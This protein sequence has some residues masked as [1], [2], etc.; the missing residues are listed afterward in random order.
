ML[1]LFGAAIAGVP[2]CPL[3]YRLADE[4]LG[5]LLSRIAPALVVG[6]ASR[7]AQLGG[8]AQHAILPRAAFT[9]A[10]L[11]ADPTEEPTGDGESIAIQ[12]FTSGTTSAPKAAI[13]TH[14]NLVSYIVGTV[15]FGAAAEHE[16]TLVSV[17]PYHS[18]GIAALLSSVYA[19]RRIVL[20]PAFAPEAWLQLVA[21]ERVTNAFVVPTMLNR[22]V[23]A[24]EGRKA[25]DLSSLRAI[26]KATISSTSCG[27][28]AWPDW[29]CAM[30]ATTLRRSVSDPV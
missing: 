26:A 21:D 18:A 23:G 19:M 6:D 24:L 22:I 20:L 27:A 12:L 7:A 5:L 13:L 4:D 15:E 30:V 29:T 1:A 16:A 11:A 10:G 28:K 2:Y 25:V 9:E 14:G 17:P 8:E 3:N